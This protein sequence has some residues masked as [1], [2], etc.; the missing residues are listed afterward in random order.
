MLL[1]RVKSAA[2]PVVKLD[3]PARVELGADLKVTWTA[4]D[5]D[6][7]ALTSMVSISLDGGATWRSLGD[8]V[9]GTSLTVKAIV[10]L[11]GTDVRVRVAT[12]D[13]WN[14][15]TAD[16]GSFVVGGTLTDGTVVADNWFGGIWTAGMDG[17]GAKELTK[18][19]IRP[20]WSPDGS[21]LVYDNMQDLF[22]MRGDGSEPHRVSTLP[23][24]DQY[25][26]PLW[27]PDGDKILA[28][29]R[30]NFGHEANVLVDPQ[31]GAETPFAAKNGVM[32][33]YTRDGSRLLGTGQMYQYSFALYRADG[34]APVDYPQPITGYDCMSLSPDGRFG[35]VA[36]VNSDADS[37]INIVVWDL[38]TKTM[39][40][41]T[42]NQ[43]GG[44]NAYPT[45]SPTGDWIVFGS[46]RDRGGS[47]GFGSTD[48]WK[49]RPDGTGAQ[50]IM[51]GKPG[52]QSFERP[53]VQPRRGTAP[54]LEPTLVERLPVAAVKGAAGVEGADITLDAGAS[55]PGA[56]DAALASFA[57]DLDGDG[58]YARRDA[59]P[60]RS[61]GSPTMAPTP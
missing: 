1:T 6:G 11:A 43:F 49:I 18:N 33:G 34:T 55:K 5:A 48:L 25:L 50:K 32:C 45:W 59:A 36:R 29:R 51:D 13:G 31:T 14:T 26:W 17:T 35:V 23:S 8:A 46:N 37:R 30:R 58:V 28:E 47:T 4:N 61:S 56:D 19:G 41:L 57:W 52:G 53:D 27:T 21:K 38:Q 54:D 20:K 44:Y 22:T 40:N 12:T 7:D 39:R 9:T 15:T 24:S 60:R 10:Q 16:S 2:A 42:N 3:T